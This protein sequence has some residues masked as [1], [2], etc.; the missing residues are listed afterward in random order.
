[1]RA[2]LQ[3]L[4]ILLFIGIA[5]FLPLFELFEGGQD[6]EDGADTVQSIL[7]ALT[8]GALAILLTRVIARLGHWLQT[9]RV[10]LDILPEIQEPSREVEL[11]PPK[12]F[13]RFCA[14]LI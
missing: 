2:T 3:Y 13:L 1:M 8:C 12:L 4:G 14:V 9:S 5:F 6:L 11:T 7:S 10:V